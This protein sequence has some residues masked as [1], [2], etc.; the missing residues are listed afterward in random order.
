MHRPMSVLVVANVT[1]TS[2]ELIDALLTRARRAPERLTLLM[3]CTGP[4]LHAR[5]LA[6]PR[7]DAALAAWREAGLAGD[8]VVGDEDP[9]EAVHE[10]WDPREFDEIV[11]S[12]LPGPASRWLSCD[13]PR[14]LLRMT[15]A[16]VT[17]VRSTARG[18]AVRWELTEERRRPARAAKR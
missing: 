15:D 4:G 13:L 1:A 16:Q 18:P 2:P 5:D 10:L 12:T 14:R 6:R 7:L 3:P 11:V 8:G 17:H 9:L